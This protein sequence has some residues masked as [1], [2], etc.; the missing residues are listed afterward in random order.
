MKSFK[1]WFFALMSALMLLGALTACSDTSSKTD[2]PNTQ[3]TD[4][5]SQSDDG[6]SGQ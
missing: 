2:D 1:K 6:N 3:Q 4:D 5:G